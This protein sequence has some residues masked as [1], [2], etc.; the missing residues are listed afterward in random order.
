MKN[1]DVSEGLKL[2]YVSVVDDDCN[3]R[4]ND[5]IS[6]TPHSSSIVN[7]FNCGNCIG[8]DD[9][10]NGLVVKHVT[11]VVVDAIV[12]GA[13]PDDDNDEIG[14]V[15]TTLLPLLRMDDDENAYGVIMK[16]A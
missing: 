6:I 3:N 4:I 15:I 16:G 2:K 10:G 13:V 8:N 7:D 12:G 14:D 5:G 1:S 11:T 9:N